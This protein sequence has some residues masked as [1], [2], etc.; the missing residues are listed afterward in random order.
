MPKNRV[1]EYLCPRCAE[2]TVSRDIHEGVTPFLMNCP[3]CKSAL[4]RSAFYRVD[5]FQE[6]EV[7]WI[8]PAVG[9]LVDTDHVRQGGLVPVAASQLLRPVVIQ[10]QPTPATCLITSFAMV[11][12]VHV[13]E[14]IEQIGHNGAQVIF[15]NQS[16]A[17][18]CRGH[19]IQELIAALD[20]REYAIVA[21]EPSPVSRSGDE[22][23]EHATNPF[24]ESAM[25]K[26]SGVIAGRNAR[27]EHAVAWSAINRHSYDPSSGREIADIA[28]A[29]RTFYAVIPK[30]KS[31]LVL[32]K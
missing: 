17:N 26:Y 25:L 27:G 5:Q 16:G 4:A 9:E 21:I 20:A 32:E 22:V 13:D 14:L 30:I 23:Y 15:P 18:R 24:I 31:P 10:R 12:G 3:K 11:L 1:N 19:H 28:L 7:L 6:A 2:K 29:I 8:R